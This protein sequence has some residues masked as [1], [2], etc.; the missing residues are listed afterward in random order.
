MAAPLLFSAQFASKF[1][2]LHPAF[3]DIFVRADG[4]K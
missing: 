3:A 2:E 1:D 4:A